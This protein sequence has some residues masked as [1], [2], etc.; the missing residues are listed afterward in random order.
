MSWCCSC[1]SCN[2][3]IKFFLVPV[4]SAHWMKKSHKV[5]S[6]KIHRFSSYELKTLGGG[7]P[8]GPSGTFRVKKIKKQNIIWKIAFWR[9]QWYTN[10]RFR[11]VVSRL[12]K[13]WKSERMIIK[14]RINKMVPNV[15]YWLQI[16]NDSDYQELSNKGL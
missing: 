8:R 13:V 12:Q 5:L 16:S 4:N 15:L 10:Q 3:I 9:H 14:P 2:S 1:S 7:G 11:P 6:E